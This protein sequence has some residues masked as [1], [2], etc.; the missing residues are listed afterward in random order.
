[1]VRSTYPKAIYILLFHHFSFTKQLT[2]LIS[3][4]K[5][6]HSFFT[7]FILKVISQTLA[8]STLGNANDTNENSKWTAL[9]IYLVYKHF[10]TT[11]FIY[12]YIYLFTVYAL[13]RGV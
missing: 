1:M 7:S 11:L 5:S 10:L 12:K 8:K 13:C 4:Q 6:L 9:F 3:L 2:F